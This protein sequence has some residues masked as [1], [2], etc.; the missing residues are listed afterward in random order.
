[1]ICHKPLIA[2]IC[3]AVLALVTVPAFGQDED[4]MRVERIKVVDQSRPVFNIY[5]DDDNVKWIANSEAIY[6][7]VA[8]D[9]AERI[10]IPSGQQ[11]LLQLPGGNADVRWSKSEISGI[12]G[13]AKITTA[14]YDSRDQMLWIGTDGWGVYKIKVSGNSLRL[15]EEIYIDNSKLRSDFINL[16]YISP[17]KKIWIATEDGAMLI[18]GGSASVFQKYFNVQTISGSRRQTWATGDG[19]VWIIDSRDNWDPIEINTREIEGEM[20]DIAFDDEGNIW[21]ASNIM[22][23]YNIESQRYRHFGPGQYFTSQF[24]NYVSV[25]DDGTIWVGTDDKGVYIIEKA[26]TITL[27]TNLDKG[28][29]CEGGIADAHV[30][31]RAVGG[32]P[33]Y[34]FTWS[35]GG[36]GQGRED[37]AAGQYVITVTD[38][39]GS[40]K[41]ADFEVPDPS[42]QV[43]VTQEEEESSSG[44]SDGIAML[45][46]EGGVPGYNA[47]W[48]TGASGAR[49]SGL[50]AGQY[51]VTV[52]DQAGCT[53]SG[54]VR[55]TTKPDVLA[56]SVAQTNVIKCQGGDDGANIMATVEGGVPPYTYTW[57]DIAGGEEEIRG[58]SPGTYTVTIT[59]AAGSTAISEVTIEAPADF[60]AMATVT[61]SATTD[62]SDGQAS[63]AIEG[64]LEPFSY[65]WS[66]GETVADAVA[67]PPGEH[68]VTVTDANGCTTVASVVVTEDILPL[69]MSILQQ[70]DILCAGDATGSATVDIAGGKGPFT[71]AWSNGLTTEAAEGLTAGAYSVT[72][73]D[74]LGTTSLFTTEITE[75]DPMVV[76]VAV[77]AAATANN[78]D[79]SASVEVTGGAGE[80]TYAWDNGSTAATAEALAAG[81]YTVTVTDANGCSNTA[82]VTMTEDIVPLSISI[83]QQGDILCAGEQTGGL[84]VDVTG[85]KSPYTYSWADGLTTQVREDLGAG[86]YSVTVTDV[87]GS[88]AVFESELTEPEQLV[89]NTVI[90]SPASTDMADGVATA[91]ATGGVGEYTYQWT[92]GVAEA[93]A[94]NLGPEE[95]VIT[96]TDANGCSATASVV[97]TENILPLAVELV[98]GEQILCNG[99][100]TG[101]A[102]AQVTGGKGPFSYTWANSTYRLV[103]T[104]SYFRKR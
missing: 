58:L 52:T 79:G 10:D 30:T 104:G 49:L 80:Y 66:H 34:T 88:T 7:V 18:D 95:H 41:T 60:S 20:H 12:L 47:S 100:N 36:T 23:S 76:N 65:N 42:I 54:D 31:A 48:S 27:T 68:Q 69:T 6:K 74:A 81:A 15:I 21:I 1:M 5:V 11:S 43:T 96:V 86:I 37:L 24:V 71:Y 73:T 59:D 14:A 82:M 93:T 98:Q 90:E 102:T 84:L 55:I 45:L 13:E 77:T 56:V 75:P 28:L 67:L 17:E 29:S 50:T 63:I 35:D 57:G 103:G 97:I 44:A 39:E 40:S 101:S 2:R 87:T 19:L 8:K 91:T 62:N 3:V 38:S 99:L 46:A 85:G 51:S 16:I 64:G 9:Q 53:A 33:P 32:F 78:A 61:Q 94:S 70:D 92:N 4:P 26:S 25:D 89:L 83:E 22:T 72:V